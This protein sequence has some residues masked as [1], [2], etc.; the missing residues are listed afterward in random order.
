[1]RTLGLKARSGVREGAGVQLILIEH[2]KGGMLDEPG[3][4]TF[5]FGLKGLSAVFQFHRNRF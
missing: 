3:K 4:V 2:A 1:M 5:A